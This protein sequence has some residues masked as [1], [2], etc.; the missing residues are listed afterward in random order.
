M[1]LITNSVSLYMDDYADDYPIK[2]NQTYC[3]KLRDVV[4]S[5]NLTSPILDGNTG[6][7]ISLEKH[8]KVIID[9]NKK[10]NYE[11]VEICS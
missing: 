8:V 2:A 9:S 3:I 1:K 7:E 10:L 5:G 4:L 11:L 6:K